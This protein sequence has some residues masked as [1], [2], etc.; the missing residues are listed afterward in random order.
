MKLLSCILYLRQVD[1]V[2]INW[3]E[4]QIL[5]GE[6]KWGHEAVSRQIVRELID[7]K[8]PLVTCDLPAEGAGWQ[9]HYALFARAG[10]TV[11]ALTELGQGKSG[12]GHCSPHLSH[13]ACLKHI[14]LVDS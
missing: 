10:F 5:L 3:T 2:A 13:A 4:R 9:I 7:R 8:V 6:C 11:A 1:V 12:V 14:V